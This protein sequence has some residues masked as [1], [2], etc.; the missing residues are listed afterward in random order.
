VDSEPFV[1]CPSA[2]FKDYLRAVDAKRF[3]QKSK[4]MVIGF[5]LNRW[6]GNTHLVEVAMGPDKLVTPGTGLYPQ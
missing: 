4:Q 1:A 3:G 5:A 2:A 6:G